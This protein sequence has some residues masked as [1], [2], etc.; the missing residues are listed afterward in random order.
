MVQFI[1]SDGKPD[2]RTDRILRTVLDK[3]LALE[4]FPNHTVRVV[5]ISNKESAE[6]NYQ[7]KKKRTPGDVFS[8]P[9][10]EHDMLGEVLI[11]PQY[12]RTIS[13]KMGCD[14][15]DLLVRWSVHGL[16][17]ILGYDHETPEDY[18]RMIQKEREVIMTT[19]REFTLP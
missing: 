9:R 15:N 13:R 8:F 2:P 17:H 19:G 5:W 10:A 12:A 1:Q 11:S 6:V 7:M 16:F 3:G 14:M 4:G 18:S